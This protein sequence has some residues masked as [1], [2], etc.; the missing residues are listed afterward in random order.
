MMSS[1]GGHDLGRNHGPKHLLQLAANTMPA[2]LCQSAP[3]HA[4]RGLVRHEPEALAVRHPAG[5]QRGD[6]VH[7]PQLALPAVAEG[8]TGYA[9]ARP[10]GVRRQDLVEPAH[11]QPA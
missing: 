7:D 8:A 11:V 9:V 2:A 4:G 5:V 1:D 10:V 3:L 6:E